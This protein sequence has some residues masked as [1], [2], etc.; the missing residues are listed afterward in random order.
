[1]GQILDNS[2]VDL[3]TIKARLDIDSDDDRYNTV[4]TIFLA[5]AKTLVDTFCDGY[6]FGEII[7]ADVE[8]WIVGMVARMWE[9]QTNGADSIAITSVQ[10][11]SWGAVDYTLL[12]GYRSFWGM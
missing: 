7:P 10:Q 1:M 3:D 5:G 2:A 6:T 4:L 12:M 9:Q 11:I 8:G